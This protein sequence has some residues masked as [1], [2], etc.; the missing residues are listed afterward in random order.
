MPYSMFQCC[1][2]NLISPQS[3]TYEKYKAKITFVCE[4]V[5]LQKKF[6]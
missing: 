4:V 1:S 2:K 3:L 6:T 5:A